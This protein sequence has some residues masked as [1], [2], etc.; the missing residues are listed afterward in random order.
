MN[1]PDQLTFD[2]LYTNVWENRDILKGRNCIMFV[3]G[4]VIGKDNS[5]DT[6]MPHETY[7][8]YEQLQDLKNDGHILAW[9]TWSHPDL[10]TLTEEQIRKELTAPAEFMTELAYPYGRYNDLVKKIAKEMGYTRAWSVTQG[11]D[12]QFS[13]YRA[14]V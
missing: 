13:L 1:C 5:F 12:D 6:G 4:D 3:V 8:T 2:G 14:Y 9:H 10:T 7:C 11:N